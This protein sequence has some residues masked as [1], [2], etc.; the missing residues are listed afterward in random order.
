MG[1]R[2]TTEITQHELDEMADIAIKCEGAEI[3]RWEWPIA[4][5]L[6]DRDKRF[7]L[8]AAR[9]PGGDFK[10]LYY[11]DSKPAPAADM[12]DLDA[13]EQRV[14]ATIRRTK[15]KDGVLAVER[16]ISEA[17]FE[18]LMRAARRARMTAEQ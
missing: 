8:G 17:D 10:R 16:I 11:D 13:I 18:A 4:E 3:V 2:R 6:C 9:G 1:K 7:T 15:G 5:K 12:A 14:R